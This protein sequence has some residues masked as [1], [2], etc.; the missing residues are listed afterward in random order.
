MI[1]QQMIM[2]LEAYASL[3]QPTCTFLR[4]V[5]ENQLREACDAAD[6]DNLQNLV[7]IVRWCWSNLPITSWGSTERVDAWLSAY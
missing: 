2:E 7:S 6:E 1:R 3:H 4:K 5:L